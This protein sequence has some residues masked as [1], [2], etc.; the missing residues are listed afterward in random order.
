[1]AAPPA[2]APR[3]TPRAPTPPPV[4]RPA[5]APHPAGVDRPPMI[6]GVPTKRPATVIPPAAAAS[7]G[8]RSATLMGLSPISQMPPARPKPPGVTDLSSPPAAPAPA[9]PAPAAPAPDAVAA[10]VDAAV[11]AAAASAARA[12]GLDPSGPEM[13][14]IVQLSREVIEQVV[15]EVVPDLAETIIRE[16]LDRLA[17]SK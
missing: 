11:P 7:K 16:N 15:W 9:A 14:A 10:R 12:A 4:A 17:A 13:K 2:A 1:P 6:K 5:A 8:G 3:A